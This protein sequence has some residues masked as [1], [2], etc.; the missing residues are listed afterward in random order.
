MAFRFLRR[1]IHLWRQRQVDADLAEELTFHR[2][3]KRQ[4]LEREGMPAPDAAF[5]SQRVLGNLTRA[6]C[7]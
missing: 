6:R 2:E 5:A 1:L 4:E 7:E 3:M